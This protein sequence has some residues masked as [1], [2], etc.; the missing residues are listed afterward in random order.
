MAMLMAGIK[1]EEAYKNALAILLEM[2]IF[3]Q[4]QDDYLDCY[5]DPAV[6]GKIGTDIQ[7][8]KCG[9]LVVQALKL[10]T[11]EQRQVLEVRCGNSFDN[12][13]SKEAVERRLGDTSR[14]DKGRNVILER[15]AG[16]A[17]MVIE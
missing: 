3:F 1:D 14:D 10:A 15:H 17:D 7:D 2:G 12:R 6:I 4:V 13:Q 16:N 11:P 9:W 5:G 8:N